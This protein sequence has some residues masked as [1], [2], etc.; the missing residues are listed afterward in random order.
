MLSYAATIVFSRIS[1]YS[2]ARYCSLFFNIWIRV[3]CRNIIHSKIAS[4]RYNA[5]HQIQ[6]IF[7][8]IGETP[9]IFFV[10]EA[11]PDGIIYPNYI[12]LDFYSG[13]TLSLYSFA[14]RFRYWYHPTKIS[15]SGLPLSLLYS[16]SCWESI[17]YRWQFCVGMVWLEAQLW[18]SRYVHVGLDSL[19]SNRDFMCTQY[20][21]VYQITLE[22]RWLFICHTSVAVYWFSSTEVHLWIIWW[23]CI[24]WKSVSELFHFILCLRYDYKMRHNSVRIVEQYYYSTLVN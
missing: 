2:Q 15:P 19:K 22:D 6:W 16:I 10:S 24:W 11:L 18:G 7:A 1:I 14:P 13:S 8:K 3:C 17:V 4:Y 9:C 12:Y 21:A 20:V 5:H 23:L